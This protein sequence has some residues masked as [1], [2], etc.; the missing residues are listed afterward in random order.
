[1]KRSKTGLLQHKGALALVGILLLGSGLRFYGLSIQSLWNDEFNSWSVSTSNSLSGILADLS[2][3][4]S[5]VHPPGYYLLLHVVTGLI[6]ESEWALRLPSAIAGVFSI[7]V[8]YLLGRRLFSYKE[9][10]VAALLMAVLWTPIHYSPEARMYSLLILFTMLATYFWLPVLRS[11][12]RGTRADLFA[13][14]GYVLA[15]AI[16]AYLHYFGLYLIALQGAYATLLHLRR[17]KKLA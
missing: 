16:A 15:A 1:M 2:G 8:I 13:V 6:G 17:P 10:L 11:V 9:G 4:E 12:D 3:E 14:L 7:F 5:G